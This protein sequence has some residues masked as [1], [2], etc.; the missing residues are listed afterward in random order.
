MDKATCFEELW[1]WQ[2]ARILVRQIYGDCSTGL[3]AKDFEFR[4][5]VRAAGISIMNNVAE[6]WRKISSTAVAGIAVTAAT[7]RAVLRLGSRR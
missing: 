2:Q 7:Q 4:N 3:A 1:I 5:H 6:A